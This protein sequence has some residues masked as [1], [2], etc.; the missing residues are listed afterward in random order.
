MNEKSPEIATLQ[1]NVGTLQTNYAALSDRVDDIILS[2]GRLIA[3]GG[4]NVNTGAYGACM[5]IAAFNVISGGLTKVFL[6]SALPDNTYAVVATSDS[7]IIQT[8]TITPTTDAFYVRTS[9]LTGGN[10]SPSHLAV[11]VFY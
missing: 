11:A 8:H 9:N 4:F 5:G 6:N 1:T 2:S 7:P 3:F 10:S